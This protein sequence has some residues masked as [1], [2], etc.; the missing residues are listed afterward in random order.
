MAA[1]HANEMNIFISAS[2][3]YIC[4]RNAFDFGYIELS[5]FPENRQANFQKI[6]TVYN[7]LY[8]IMNVYVSDFAIRTHNNI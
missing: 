5:S 1:R 2:S 3:T 7:A 6:V 8:Y 4:S